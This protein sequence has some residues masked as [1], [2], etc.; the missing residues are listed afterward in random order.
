MPVTVATWVCTFGLEIQ[1]VTAAELTARTDPSRTPQPV[2]RATEEKG[3]GDL[4]DSK[5]LHDSYS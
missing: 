3:I 4:S 2:H 1:P 5:L